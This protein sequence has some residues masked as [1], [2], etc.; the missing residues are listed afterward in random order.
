[1]K[2]IRPTDAIR[3]PTR[4]ISGTTGFML[5][6]L[7]S[8]FPLS[9]QAQDPAPSQARVLGVTSPVGEPREVPQGAAVRDHRTTG[10]APVTNMT[11]QLQTPSSGS[12]G[13][14]SVV[15]GIIEPDYK[16]PWMVRMNGCG[17]VLIDP[18]WVL[19]AAHCVTA[20]IGFNGVGYKRTDPQTGM[21]RTEFIG[22]DQNSGPLNNRGVFIHPGYD[23][24]KDH[25]NDIALI[26]LARPF[27]IYPLIQT[28]ALPKYSRSSGLIGNLANFG[29]NKT[30]PPGQVAVFR[31]PMPL[32]EYP[33]K[34]YITAKAANAS[35]CP[36][37]SGSGFVTVEY[38]RATVRGVASMGNTADCMAPNGEAV[39]TDVFTHRGWIL[40]TM[41]KSEAAL[42]GN[43]RVRSSGRFARGQ[44][45]IQC[46]ASASQYG[47]LNVAG[48]EEG[49]NC[50]TGQEQVVS[51]GLDANQGAVTV[52]SAPV[53]S[54][55]TMK[56]YMQNGTSVV[57]S[58]G[59]RGNSLRVHETFPQGAVAREFSC[60]IGTATTS[61]GVFGTNTTSTVLK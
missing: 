16:Y 55:I 7:A 6:A 17:G 41:G 21:E 59:S 42:A 49:S 31:A 46:P 39:F 22:P 35:L 43:T 47:P 25:A 32:G 18:Q 50:A 4:I 19:T 8:S 5:L 38:G 33:P 37:D 3:L 20:R 48:V 30:L 58:Y 11:F 54:G 12:G 61:G 40:Q 28:V 51:C 24:A 2:N 29:H 52:A 34:F 9:V 44:M 10:G 60:L 57:K 1:M 53:L 14:S 26:K 45:G 56:T 13:T 23:A 27:G 15:G 36:G